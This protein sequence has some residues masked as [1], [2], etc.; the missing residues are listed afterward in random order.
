MLKR[1]RPSGGLTITPSTIAATEF[2][3]KTSENYYVTFDLDYE[4]DSESNY[5]ITVTG[6]APISSIT[7][8]YGEGSKLGNQIRFEKSTNAVTSGSNE[9]TFTVTIEKVIEPDEEPQV[10]SATVTITGAS[11]TGTEFT[12]QQAV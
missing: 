10:V 3:G 4:R 7:I 11:D 9:L 2:G 12:R 1:I 8:D 6:R 5:F